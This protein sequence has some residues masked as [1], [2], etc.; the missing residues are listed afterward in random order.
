MTSLKSRS[1]H[2]GARQRVLGGCGIARTT[3]VAGLSSRC[4]DRKPA[5]RDCP[6]SKSDKSLPQPKRLSR[7]GGSGRELLVSFRTVSGFV[8]GV[9]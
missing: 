7:G 3:Y 8:M 6:R 1:K 9:V 2:G 4:P 5:A